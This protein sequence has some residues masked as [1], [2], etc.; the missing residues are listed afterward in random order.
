MF[1]MTKIKLNLIAQTDLQLN[2][3]DWVDCQQSLLLRE[4]SGS[5]ELQFIL[6]FL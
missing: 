3:L 2:I 1:M 4:T 6:P 5:N